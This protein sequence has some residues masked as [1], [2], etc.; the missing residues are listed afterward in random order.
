[1]LIFG[2][3]P[4]LV[5]S[6]TANLLVNSV[7]T[8]K[9]GKFSGKKWKDFDIQHKIFSQKFGFSSKKKTKI[10]KKHFSKNLKM[11]IFSLR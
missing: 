1:M 2:I 4:L 8:S 11:D 9:N 5:N 3:S 7:F 10:P 6:K